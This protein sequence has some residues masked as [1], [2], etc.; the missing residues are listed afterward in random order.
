MAIVINNTPAS[1]SSLHGDLIFT[2]YEATKANDP[3]TYPNYKYVCDVYIGGVM[4][5]RAKAFP[6]PVNKRCVFNIA[7]I[8]RNYMALQ[9]AP[10]GA[11]IL[12]QEFGPNQFY[13]DVQCKF[14]EEYSFTTYTNLTIDS[15]RRYYNHYNNQIY[16]AQSIL[17]SYVDNLASNRP[18]ANSLLS[19][20]NNFYVP[21]WCVSG[22]LAITVTTFSVPTFS[23]GYILDT[24][25][26]IISTV[27]GMELLLA[28]TGYVSSTATGSVSIAATSGSLQQLNFS[29]AA[30][31][32]DIPGLI[33]ATIDYYVVTINGTINLLY[34]VKDEA[35]FNPYCLHFLNQIGGFDSVSF[36]KLSQKT[37]EVE[38]K[39]Y[40]QQPFRIDGSGMAAY[41][42]SANVVYE[43][44]TT[45]SSQF[46]RKM[47]LS[48]DL[49]TDKE[50]T[51]LKELFFSP[52]VYLQDGSYIVPVSITGTSYE[53]NKFVNRKSM[54]ACQVDIEF[55]VQLNSQYR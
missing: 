32:Y 8:V 19:S 54:Q 12:V 26:R 24:A 45:Y 36:Q 37:Y 2:A 52:L 34:K 16:G 28:G 49:L 18:Y 5:Y 6:N 14:G 48:T 23:G 30:I 20:Y 15:S 50:W 46:K 4:I 11:G 17:G 53:E 22:S 51:W 42:N 9:F 10:T 33:D 29:A 27:D 40:T 25:S 41:S 35:I 21:Y 38:K 44:A 55:G 47:K 39:S 3:V 43:T 13:L 7:S 31:N 1:Y